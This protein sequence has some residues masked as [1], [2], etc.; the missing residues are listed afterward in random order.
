MGLRRDS[1]LY[2]FFHMTVIDNT[3]TAAANGDLLGHLPEDL[4]TAILADVRTGDL[5]AHAAHDLDEQG[6]YFQGHLL[7]TDSS[8]GDYRLSDGRWSGQWRD[9]AGADSRESSRA[10]AWACCRLA[11]G[12]KVMAEYRFSL[13]HSREVARLQRRLDAASPARTSPN[14]PPKVLA[15]TTRRSAATSATA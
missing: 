11:G 1:S 8:L 2:W 6:N 9:L 7:L 4:R 14:C 12:G 5:Q 15:P 13:R 10:L 3:A